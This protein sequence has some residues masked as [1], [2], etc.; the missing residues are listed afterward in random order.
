MAGEQ[1]LKLSSCG[2][3]NWGADRGFPIEWIHS[4]LAKQEMERDT[5]VLSIMCNRHL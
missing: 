5:L 2:K 4:L 3:C 1:S